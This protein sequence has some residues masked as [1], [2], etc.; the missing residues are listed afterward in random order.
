MIILWI[1]VLIAGNAFFVAAEFG[2]VS[3]RRSTIE[4]RARKGGRLAKTTLE[5]M[6]R[7][8]QLLAAAQ[9]GVTLCSLAIGAIGEPLIAR[10]LKHPFE[11]AH[12]PHYLM[13]PVSIALALVIMTYLHAVF[14]EMIPK[15]IALAKSERTALLFT[16]PLLGLVRLLYPAV[17]IL[18]GLSNVSVRLLGVTPKTEVTSSFTADEFAGFVEESH[19][20]GLLDMGERDLLRGT[21]EFDEKTV[22]SLVLPLEQ[23]VKVQMDMTPAEIEALV[24]RTGYSRFPVEN[25]KGKLTGYIH[26]KDVIDIDQ[27]DY[28]KP[29]H[30]KEIRP[31]PSVQA[32]DSLQDALRSMQ[33]VG[34]HLAQ[35]VNDK[36]RVLGVVMLEDALEELVGEIRDSSRRSAA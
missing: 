30:H 7:I 14:G 28:D 12:L 21:L 1:I 6:E 8:S 33:K 31:L 3:S 10:L 22:S 36:G 35:V 2:L 19:R 32:T 13:H 20:E 27:K 34:V 5:G 29:L 17:A 16:P 24:V 11:L 23:V 18:N 15:N 26:L 9:L 4:A 25:A